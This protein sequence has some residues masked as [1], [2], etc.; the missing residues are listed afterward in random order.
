MECMRVRDRKR[1][2]D[3][4]LLAWERGR[5]QDAFF[6]HTRGEKKEGKR[7]SILA[8]QKELAPPRK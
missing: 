2:E 5:R 6:L 1:R 4:G 8:N 7:K 3:F